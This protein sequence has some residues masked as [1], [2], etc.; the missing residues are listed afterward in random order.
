MF[1]DWRRA[2]RNA[3]DVPPPRENGLSSGIDISRIK[4]YCRSC[5]TAS[6]GIVVGEPGFQKASFSGSDAQFRFELMYVFGPQ[7]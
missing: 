1:M 2:K 7:E 5:G 3:R 4:R 6:T